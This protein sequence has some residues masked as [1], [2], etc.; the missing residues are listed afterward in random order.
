MSELKASGDS[1]SAFQE[2]AERYFSSVYESTKNGPGY[3]SETDADWYCNQLFDEQQEKSRTLQGELLRLIGS[4]ATH[5]KRSPLLTEADENDLKRCAKELRAA[6]R[7]HAYRSWD[8]EILHDEDIVLGVRHAGQSESHPASPREASRAFNSAIETLSSLY[9]LIEASPNASTQGD[10]PSTANA[11]KYRPNTVFVMMWIDP[12]N[13]T[14]EDTYGTIKSA[15]TKFGLHALRA[16]EIEH[17]E[18]ITERI[19]SE[20]KTSEFLIADLT[21]ERPSAYYEIGYAHSLGK[22]V[23]MYRRQGTRVHFDL[24]AYNCPEYRNNTELNEKLLKRLED[25]TNRRRTEG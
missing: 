23:I 8:T 21:G 19:L 17:E 4:L 13:P 7:L 5:V 1:L 24:A 11:A 25:A 6:I 2:E 22:R 18:V 10:F 9:E 15:C 16:D 20:I 14:L 12:T 3:F